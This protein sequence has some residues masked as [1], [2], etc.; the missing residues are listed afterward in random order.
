MRLLIYTFAL[1]IL[2]VMAEAN[3]T[4]RDLEGYWENLNTHTIIKVDVKPYELRIKGI[5]NR[6]KSTR[7]TKNRRGQYIDS[8]GNELIIRSRSSII[9]RNRHNG[10]NTRF[11]RPAQYR[12]RNHHTNGYTTKRYNQYGEGSYSNRHLYSQDDGYYS[13]R[14]DREEQNPKDRNP[15]Q[16]PSY[17]NPLSYSPDRIDDTRLKNLEGTWRNQGSNSKKVIIVST[18]DG[19]KVKDTS[20]D[21][22]HRYKLSTDRKSLIDDKGNL[23]Q[24]DAQSMYWTAHNEKRILKLEKISKNTF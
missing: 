23:Y 5:Y 17:H 18:R 12:R 15:S 22:W 3:H 20:N 24:V 2:P 21:Q 1:A 6:R 11:T 4:E 16:S 10:L 19:I 13:Q 14:Y 9:F 7:F 8:R